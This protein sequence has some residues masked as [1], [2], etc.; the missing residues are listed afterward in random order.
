MTTVLVS[1]GGGQVGRSIRDLLGHER[2]SHLSVTVADRAALDITDPT[3]IAAAMERVAP[4][5]VIN[6]AAYTAVDA[7]EADEDTAMAVN[8]HAVRSLAAACQEGGARLIQF[9]TDYVFDGTKDGWYVEAD[10]IA[11]LG[12]YGRSKAAGEDAARGCADHLILRTAWV[13]A[14]HGHNFVKTML[15]LGA[16]R[17]RLAVVAD[18][19]GCPTSAHDLAAAALELAEHD[20]TGTYHL[21]GAEAATWH[22]FAEA[23][24]AEAALD[25]TVD[26]I[27]T[28]DYPTPA[29]RPTNS[30]LDS[31]A[32][33]AVTGVRLPGWNTSLPGVVAAILTSDSLRT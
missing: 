28:V 32:L 5:V 7:A 2:F 19:I 4:D 25:V 29:P 21:A 14:R 22:E 30:R 20:V 6:A 17:D 8:A 23:V 33:A 31:T 15:R 18:Q 3:S 27:G 24:F 26:A 11:P 12:V 1:G 10:P 13:Y 9:S 16:E